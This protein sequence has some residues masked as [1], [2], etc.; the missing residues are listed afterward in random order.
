MMV[1]SVML[2]VLSRG[3]IR[4][5]S[6]YL[7][8]VEDDGTHKPPSATGH[9]AP[10]HQVL[11]L[12]DLHCALKPETQDQHTMSESCQGAGTMQRELLRPQQNQLVWC[13]Y[14]Q[15][16]LQLILCNVLLRFN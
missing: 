4:Q 5:K 8:V 2:F 1:R 3:L 12:G 9:L 16:L 7:A 15:V 10:V 14:L 13:W 6:S 11:Q